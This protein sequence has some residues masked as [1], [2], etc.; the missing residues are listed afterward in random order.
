MKQKPLKI[1]W[2]AWCLY[3]LS[4]RDYSSFEMENL[5]QKRAKESGQEVDPVPIVAQLVE[6]GTI[7]DDRYVQSQ[8]RLYTEIFSS[9]GP[10]E[11]RRHLKTK[12][13]I[14]S[15][16][17]DQYIDND[18]RQWYQTALKLRHKSL[19]E[20]G[21]SDEEQQEIPEKVFHTIKQKLY[22]KGFTE[23]QIGFGMQGLKPIRI[24][25]VQDKSFN[26]EKLIESR[27]LSGKGPYEIKQFLLQKGVEKERIQ[28]HLDFPEEVWLEIAAREREKRFGGKK[29]KTMKEK[30]KQTDFLQR[31]GFDFEQIKKVMV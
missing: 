24:R 26:V 8:V 11:L 16:M 18:D 12:G 15:E 31:R 28:D 6:E 1:S 9:K 29:P 23:Q 27:M 3:K 13:G 21:F 17:I 19:S 20:K 2:R 4:R 7:D 30:R 5:I 22:R 10:L 14:P 25:E